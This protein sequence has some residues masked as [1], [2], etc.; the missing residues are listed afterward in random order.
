M[1]V[2]QSDGV[3]AV[4]TVAAILLELTVAAALLIFLGARAAPVYAALQAAVVDGEAWYL[5]HCLI[6]SSEWVTVGW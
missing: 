1:S 5:V 4:F 2:K 6:D 3:R